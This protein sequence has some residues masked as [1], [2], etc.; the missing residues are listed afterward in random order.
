MSLFYTVCLKKLCKLIFCQNFVK[1]ITY[2]LDISEQHVR[3]VNTVVL[4]DAHSSGNP[5]E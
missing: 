2:F 5:S 1:Y 4:F 3:A